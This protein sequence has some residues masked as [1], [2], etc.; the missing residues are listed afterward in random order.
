MT[1]TNGVLFEGMSPRVKPTG[2]SRGE[3]LM[4]NRLARLAKM[5]QRY[6]RTEGVTCKGCPFLTRHGGASRS[7]A[8]CEKAGTSGSEAT[9]WSSRWTA[10]GAKEFV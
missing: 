2:G 3:R 4:R 5:H 8:K 10:C 9:D 7:W 6:G 1:A